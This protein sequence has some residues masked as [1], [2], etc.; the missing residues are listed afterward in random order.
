MIQNIPDENFYLVRK[1]RF[2]DLFSR[3]HHRLKFLKPV[4]F[5]K[6]TENFNLTVKFRNKYFIRLPGFAYRK[7]YMFRLA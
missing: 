5:K 4:E 7:I 2:C 6:F 1:V 3:V